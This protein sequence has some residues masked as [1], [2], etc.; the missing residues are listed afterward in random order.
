MTDNKYKESPFWNERLPIKE[1]ISYLLNEMTLE[2]KFQFLATTTPPLERLGIESFHIGGEASHGV[3]A[4]HDQGKVREAERT[5]SFTQPIGMS[6]SFDTDLMEEVGTIVGTE[7]RVLYERNREGGLSRWA[8]TV[9]MERDPRWGRTEEGYGEDPY[10][11][12]AMASAYICGLQG[13]HSFYLRMAASL[14]HFYANNVEEGRIWKSSFVDT[15]NKYEYYLEPFRRAVEQGHAE[16]MMTAYN[17]INGIP[18]ILN[19]E[20]QDLVKDQWGLRGHVVCDGGDMTQTVE[21]HHFYGTHAETVAEGLKAGVDCFTDNA[22]IVE[23]AVR[24]AYLLKLITVEDINRA[25]SNS[26]GT[27]IRLGIYDK[28]QRNPYSR[29]SEDDINSRYHQEVC[30][31]MQEEAIVL[32]KNN[33]EFLPLNKEDDVAIIGPLSDAWNLDWY[34]GEPP[35]RTTLRE[36]IRRVTGKDFDLEQGMDLVLIRFHELFLGVKENGILY[37]TKEKSEAEEVYLTDWGE[38]SFTLFSKRLQCFVTVNDEEG[39]L[40]CNKKE[41]FGWF[42]K[43]CF[44]F[45]NQENGTYLIETWNGRQVAMGEDGMP[46]VKTTAGTDCQTNQFTLQILENGLERAVELAKK[47]K[48]AILAL[49][50][51]PVINS[52]EEIDRKHISLPDFQLKLMKAV[53]EANPNIL[54]VLISNYPYELRWAQDHVPAILLSATG[55]Q[56]MGNGIARTI[57]GLNNPAGRVNMTWYESDDELLPIDDYDIIKG[58]RTYRYYKGKPLYPFGF[59]LSYG[60]FQYHNF[61]VKLKNQQEIRISLEVENT[62]SCIGDEVVQIYGRIKESRVKRPKKQLIGFKRVKQLEPAEV[63]NVEFVINI[64]EFLYYD[65]VS[66]SMIIEEG[67]YEIQA[68][69]S[70][71]A[72]ALTSEVYITG[73]CR[74][75]RNPFQITAIDHYDDYENILLGKG[76]HGYSCAYLASQQQELQTKGI[77]IYNDFR[78]AEF[79]K[80]IVNAK[81]T[82]A[83]SLRILMNDSEYGVIQQEGMKH[84]MNCELAGVCRE[85]DGF[86][87]TFILQGDMKVSRFWFE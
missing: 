29:V 82:G 27:K 55:S 84:F 62:G 49:G 81:S 63:R 54:L 52:K 67:I 61:N 68:G 53:Y 47:H 28:E 30:L 76:S 12:G 34:S 57:Y 37:F 66:A 51:N 42:V 58:E 8:P 32:L 44:N 4:R 59:G 36:G 5:T 33:Q 11:T 18:A 83:G 75:E 1:R 15:R 17:E 56:E 35:Y 24:E 73:E 45:R 69:A 26:F 22:E 43:E 10:L 20:V 79:E 64:N 9:D 65:T 21:Y 41:A 48:K 78:K 50:C 2:E 25:I 80:I 39:K 31:K 19:H 71:E 60:T 13:R 38:G 77:L 6:S 85:E 23:R 70:S 7:A 72:I 74:K 86:K 14:K 40:Y 46:F 3:E 87:L 16:A